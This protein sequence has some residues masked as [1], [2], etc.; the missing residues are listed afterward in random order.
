[1]D[2]AAKRYVREQGAGLP[3]VNLSLRRG[4]SPSGSARNIT[5]PQAAPL[6]FQHCYS[7]GRDAK[8]KR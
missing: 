2:D 8:T 4:G 6:N 7:R 5:L 3:L 1:M